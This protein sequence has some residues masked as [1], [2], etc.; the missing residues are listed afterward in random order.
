MKDFYKIDAKL[1]IIFIQ[2]P[3]RVATPTISR[4]ILKVLNLYKK[5]SPVIPTRPSCTCKA[6]Q[7]IQKEIGK[8]YRIIQ[9][10]L[11]IE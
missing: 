2:P 1:L 4:W 8:Y 7:I 6:L 9:K 5:F 10:G 3:E 11:I